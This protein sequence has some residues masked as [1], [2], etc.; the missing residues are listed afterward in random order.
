MAE[1]LTE[2]A[3]VLV[4]SGVRYR[5]HA[6]GAQMSDAKW[7]GWI[8]FI[9][10]DGGQPVRSPRETT[11][12]NRETARYWATGLT[13]VY[14][15]GALQRALNP[16]VVTRSEPDTAIFDEP[17]QPLRIE[18]TPKFSPDAVLDPLAVYEKEGEALLRRQ[19]GALAPWHLVNIIR[20]YELTDEPDAGLEGLP[21]PAL[22][23]RIVA[24][25]R[26]RE[27]HATRRAPR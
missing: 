15:E 9:P 4:A 26:L 1:V 24:A 17:E 16:I 11:Q 21:A 2:F 23:E 22:I 13:A 20:K 5:A 25:A 19:L 10:L 3:D 7:Q 18:V 14:L 8:E 12:P 6:C 27:A